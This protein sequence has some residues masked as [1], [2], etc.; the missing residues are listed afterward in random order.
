ML[1]QQVEIT[2]EMI[3]AGLAAA[4]E[5]FFDDTDASVVTPDALCEIYEAMHRL[6]DQGVCG[7]T[8]PS[9]L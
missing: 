5:H 6:S 9:R 8:H 7:E 4:R 3:A 2:D 1:G